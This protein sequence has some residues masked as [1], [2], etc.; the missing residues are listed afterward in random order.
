MV[1]LL[2]ANHFITVKSAAENLGVACTTA[3]RAIQRLERPEIVKQSGDA[4]R[5]RV[6]C[7]GALLD[8]LEEPARL[9]SAGI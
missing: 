4:K 6:Y 5:H 8:M 9:I 7:A 1:E 2:A 3:Q